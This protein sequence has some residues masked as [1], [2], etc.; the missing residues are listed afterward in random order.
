MLVNGLLLINKPAGLTSHDVVRRVRKLFGTRRV[1]H[2]GTLDPLATGVLPVALGQT[3]KLL[4]FLLTSDKRYRATLQLGVT[5]DTLD[6]EGVV[7]GEFSVPPLTEG[8]LRRTLEL[9]QGEIEQLPPMYSA[10]KK[11]GVPLYKLARQGRDIERSPR[12]VTIAELELLDW[13]T[14]S[15]TIEVDCSKGT[16][17]RSL[18]ADIG[19]ELGCGAYLQRLQRLRCGVYDISE[20]IDLDTLEA[21]EYPSE[22]LLSPAAA[23]RNYPALEVSPEAAERLRHGIAPDFE[24][25]TTSVIPHIGDLV[26]LSADG[27]LLAVARYSPHAAGQR[28]DFA[29]Q[30]VFP[31]NFRAPL[32]MHHRNAGQCN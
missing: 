15:L 19:Q 26:Q 9:F 11:N 32:A 1:G 31:D 12:R 10:L 6:A 13:N 23:M 20:C 21:L 5:T 30:R 3:T 8:G 7:T 27:R 24:A 28:G 25:V 17:I 22:R 4:Q 2:A 29:L 14:T 16:Y 18:A